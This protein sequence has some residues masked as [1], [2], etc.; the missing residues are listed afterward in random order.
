MTSSYSWRYLLAPLGARF[1]VYAPDL[2]GAGRSDK[3]DRSY[4]P[5]AVATFVGALARIGSCGGAT[6][7]PA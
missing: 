3:P 6:A 5:D 4:H 2:V 7:N 1:T